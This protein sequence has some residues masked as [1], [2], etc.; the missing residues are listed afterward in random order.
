MAYQLPKYDHENRPGPKRK[1]LSSNHPFSGD[2]LVL[3][4][5]INLTKVSSQT[6]K[7]EHF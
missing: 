4:G 2:M 6:L 3:R 1:G 5:A 7:V